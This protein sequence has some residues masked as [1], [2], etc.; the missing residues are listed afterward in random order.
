MKKRERNRNG[1][2]NNWN[3]ILFHFRCTTVAEIVRH[4]AM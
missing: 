3:W 2:I 4:D 1:K